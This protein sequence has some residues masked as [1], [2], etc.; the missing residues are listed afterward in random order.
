MRIIAGKY[1]GKRLLSPSDDNVRPT[2]DRVKETIFNILQWNIAGAYVLDLFAGSGALGIE[3]LSRGAKEVVFV[4]KN[5]DSVALVK[6]NL[7]DI[8]GQFSVVPS[9]FLSALRTLKNYR[10]DLVFIDPPYAS[11]LG[12]LA[13]DA[14]I[15]HGLLSKNGII[16]Y[17]HSSD[18]KF[19][20]KNEEYKTRTKAMGSVT[21]EFIS[22]KT[23]GLVTG[24][25]DPITVGH[26]ALIKLAAE[27]FDKVIVACLV[28]PEKKYRFDSA[29]RLA[30]VEA[31]ISELS[32]VSALYS[33]K[34]AVEVAAEVGAD[35]LVRG[36]R[37]GGFDDE[38]EKEM[39]RY[40]AERGFDTD[41]IAVDGF[42]GISSTSVKREIENGK[43]QNVPREIIEILKNNL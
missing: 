35:K 7:K 6:E 12:E 17:E 14:V 5:R 24:S 20:L 4:D 28:N 15:R 41:F 13:V 22:K 32:N 31:S 25:F 10:F 18:L 23:V 34:Q 42:N 9:D 16:V 11:K 26:K 30:M 2:T 39:A 8:D 38:Y 1:R 33:E 3:C 40:N 37:T 36:I 29:A 27:K 43:Y 21:V 19:T